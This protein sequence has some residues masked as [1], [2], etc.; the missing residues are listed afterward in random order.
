MIQECKAPTDLQLR[1]LLDSINL[2]STWGKRTY[3]MILW[4]CNTGL[5][6]SEMT[7]LRV[8]DVA[9]LGEPRD[10]VFIS[11]RIGTKTKCAFRVVPLNTTA[12]ECVAKLLEF[13]SSRGFSIAEDAP[14]FPWKNHKKLPIREA[15]REIQKLRIRAGLTDKITPHSFRHYFGTKLGQAGTD[16]YTLMTLMGHASLDAVQVYLNT[17]NRLKRN[18]VDGLPG[19]R[20]S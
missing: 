15:E 3:L 14:L 11:H 20:A 9:H 18:A 6:I 13:N 1:Q 5:R 19:R 8:K 4:L 7:A 2:H 16:G 17:S 10:E 12:Q